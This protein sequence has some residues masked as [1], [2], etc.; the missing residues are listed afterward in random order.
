[1]PLTPKTRQQLKAQAHKLKPVILLGNN[2]L[3][4]A[5]SKE[6]DRALNDHELIKIRIQSSDRDLRRA[7]FNQIC[8]GNQAELVQVI[9]SIGVIY[10]KNPD[11]K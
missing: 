5:V 10:R 3:T 7:L 1:M 4:D 9:G 8:A 2:G 11:K 6:V